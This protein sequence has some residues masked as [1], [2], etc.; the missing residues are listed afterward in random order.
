MIRSRLM[1]QHD[2]CGF[3]AVFRGFSPHKSTRTT[4][5]L[6]WYMSFLLMYDR[7]GGEF[8]RIL[9]V[10]QPRGC[11]NRAANAAVALFV[12]NSHVGHIVVRLFCGF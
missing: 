5:S 8:T 11:R 10:R 4:S 12:R 7:G 6:Y 9:H 3:C 1:L 2:A